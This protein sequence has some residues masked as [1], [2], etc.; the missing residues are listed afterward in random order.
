MS[1]I[2]LVAL[3]LDGTLISTK[4]QISQ[5][6]KTTIAR[7]RDAGVAFTMITGRMFAA[8]RPFATAIGIEGPIVCYQGAATYIVASS[9]RLAHTPIPAPIGVRVF[10]RAAQEGVRALGY[11]EDR[12]YTEVDDEFTRSY[13][14]LA[15]VEAH[16][17][18]PLAE[19]FAERPSTKINC[20]LDPKRAAAYAEEL[21]I[22]LA[23]DANVTRSQPEF[24]E[25]IDAGVDKGH[26]LQAIAQY[27]GVEL[28]ET[29]AIG[30]SWNDVPL[31]TCAG[32]G[33]AMGTA[34]PEL[35]EKADAIVAGV[36]DDG[37][38]EAIERFILSAA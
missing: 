18:G 5:N 4:L 22:W 25:V 33:V 37:V 38:A 8:A 15:R 11:F 30:D 13:T 35:T 2:R 20:V 17:V 26:A 24:V 28:T 23:G 31:L 10:A 7:A 34:P 3:D 27:Y 36:E 32:F 21:R 12:L 19:F 14:A 1:R 9:E 16:V 29:M 6:V